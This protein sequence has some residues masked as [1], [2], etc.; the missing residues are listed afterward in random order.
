MLAT[1]GFFF[2]M[3]PFN[4]LVKKLQSN[5]TNLHNVTYCGGSGLIW[6]LDG[7]ML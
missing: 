7:K 6:T 2:C 3:K 4:C 1:L 5:W